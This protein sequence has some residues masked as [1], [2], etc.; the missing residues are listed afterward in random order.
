MILVKAKK[1]CQKGKL[2]DSLEI[3]CLI[4]LQKESSKRIKIAKSKFEFRYF[5]SYT[6]CLCHPSSSSLFRL[7]IEKVNFVR[8]MSTL[9][10]CVVSSHACPTLSLCLFVHSLPLMAKTWTSPS[11]SSLLSN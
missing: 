9:A 2:S 8:A 7:G 10:T 5:F 4:F 6:F 3:I 11:Q 1:T